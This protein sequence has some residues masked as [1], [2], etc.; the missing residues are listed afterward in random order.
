MT[1]SLPGLLLLRRTLIS[2]SAFSALSG[3]VMIAAA[4]PLSQLFKIPQ[5]W[6]MAGLGAGLI[7]FAAE[8]FRHARGGQVGGAE[9]RAIIALDVAWVAGTGVLLAA[10]PELIS[11]QGRWLLIAVA[12]AV[13]VFASLQFLGLKH[14]LKRG[15]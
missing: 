3:L 13:A 10:A 1:N 2:N 15:Y 6:I 14:G 8:V 7:L 5:T 4:A 12:A 9:T 11:A